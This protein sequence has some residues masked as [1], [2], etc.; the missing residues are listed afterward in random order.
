MN[1]R[2]YG[3]SPRQARKNIERLRRMDV[4]ILIP[5][6]PLD[7]RSGKRPLV[8]PPNEHT[9]AENPTSAA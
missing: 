7:G 4:L 6:E 1:H 5:R 8:I 3:Q 2:P 9:Q